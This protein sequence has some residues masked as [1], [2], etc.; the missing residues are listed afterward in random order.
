M[1]LSKKDLNS[2]RKDDL[3][4]VYL[5]LQGEF[6]S[7]RSVHE[8]LDML[9]KN[10]EKL[11]SELVISKNVNNL[12]NK[13]VKD[14]EIRLSKSEQYSRRE[15]L[16]V[17]GMPLT[18]QQS[19]LELKILKVFEEIGVKIEPENVEA[20]HRIGKKGRAIIKL[21]RRKDVHK[22]LSNKKP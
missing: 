5:K 11:S 3:I 16:E 12:L 19:D 13:Q 9:N 6:D 7:V 17:A 20:C 18:I 8:K 4:D 14:L 21:S 15:C 1:G 22:V 10:F 2:M